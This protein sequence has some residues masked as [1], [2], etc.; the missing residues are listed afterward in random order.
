[1]NMLRNFKDEDV[2]TDRSEIKNFIGSD[3]RTWSCIT[4]D[5]D[6]I[7]SILRCDTRTDC[8]ACPALLITS[9]VCPIC[10]A[11]VSDNN[12]YDPCVCGAMIGV[13]GECVVGVSIS[14]ESYRMFAGAIMSQ[15]P[16]DVI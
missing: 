11:N 12:E 16:D 13:C 2:C 1:M 8:S 9:M 7:T 10:G 6:W 15:E 14:A 5:V 3:A 4:M